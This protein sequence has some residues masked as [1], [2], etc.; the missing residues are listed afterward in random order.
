MV[1][2]G[3]RPENLA[4][5]TSIS[6]FNSLLN[7]KDS[8][9]NNL[10]VTLEKYGGLATI[11]SGELGRVYGIPIVVSEYVRADLNATGLYDATT[12]TKTEII[13]VNKKCMI[14]GDRR[15]M[16]VKVA[17]QIQTDQTILVAT[18]RKAFSAVY[19]PAS[20]PIVSCGYNITS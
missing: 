19:P 5:V 6:G 9:G 2:Y 11:L 20:N 10:V 12:T 13:L 15:T 3:V 8:S 7:L 16:K 4:F 17:E 1:R 14:Y 18:M